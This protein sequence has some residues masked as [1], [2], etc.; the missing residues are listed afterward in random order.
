MSMT[1]KIKYSINVQIVGGTSIPI[2]GELQP[3]AYEKI[4]IAITAGEDMEVNLQPE[5]DEM[6][7]FLLIKP[8]SPG[9]E[10][11]YKVNDDTA[12]A[13][14]LDSPHLFIGKGAVSI[15]DPAPKKLFFHNGLD[16]DVTIDILLGRNVV[17]ES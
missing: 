10:L 11:T 3:E 5:G 17:P 13:I 12:T 2:T 14:S 16:S 15:L 1:E 9:P 6:A 4:Q 8:S 7:D